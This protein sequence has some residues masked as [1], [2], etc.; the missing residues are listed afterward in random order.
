[1]YKTFLVGILIGL[2]LPLVTAYLWL[3]SGRVPVATQGPPLP[4]ERA[5]TRTALRAAMRSELDKASPLQP[6][7]NVLLAGAKIYV[8][9][10]AVCHGLPESPATAIAQGMFPRPPQLFEPDRGVTD[11]PIGKIYWKVKNGIRLTGMP[12]FVSTLGDDELWQVS[13]LLL[14][15][16][17]LPTSV[18][19]VLHPEKP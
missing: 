3:N 11:D 14:K 8:A 1:M 18:Q 17:Q 9:Q 19:H 13:L 12:G 10:C 5:I 6:D 16:D 4:F 7:E 2:C 15:A